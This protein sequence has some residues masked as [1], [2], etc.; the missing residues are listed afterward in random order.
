MNLEHL[1]SKI[2][3]IDASLIRLIAER[4]KIADAIG[5]QKKGQ[6]RQIEDKA[7][8]TIVLEHIRALAQ[9]KHLPEE[10]IQRIFRQII[11]TCKRA[12]GAEV[13]FQGESGAYSEDAAVLFFGSAIQLRPCENLDSV[14]QTVQEELVSYGIVPVENSLEGSISRTYD[15]LLASDVKVCG[16]I[17]LRVSHC[18]IAH[19]EAKL[20]QITTVYSHPQA[21]GQC[22]HYLKHLK[23]ELVPTYD[24]AGSVKM[25]KAKGIINGAAI[26]GQRAAEIYGMQVLAREIEDSN[27]N[28]TRFFILSKQDTPP[29]GADKTSIVF[30]A[31]H[32]PGALH[33]AL[34]AF[35]A[36]S[37]NLTRIESRPTRQKPWEYNFYL[38]FEGHRSDTAVAATL[39]KLKR[40][41]LFVKILGSYPR[42][43]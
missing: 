28:F 39:K 4:V 6:N 23:C 15:L 13:S 30:A 26:A 10:D 36:E 12:Q 42:A 31:K 24:T 25:L 9:K 11:H 14:F 17:E 43:R 35:S 29:T 7:R 38:D 41:A 33:K 3:L 20:D 34:A 27:Q 16:E 40:A 32:S 1:R 21:L 19:P 22:Q 8:E 2:D 18:L 37:V 5:Q